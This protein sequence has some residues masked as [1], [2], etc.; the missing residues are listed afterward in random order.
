[1]KDELD[2]YVNCDGSIEHVYD[3]TL[4]GLLQEHGE[5]R[6]ER[7]SHVEPFGSGWMA[8]MSPVGGPMLL[9]WS[10]GGKGVPFATRAEALAAE[11][12]WLDLRMTMGSG[13]L[14]PRNGGR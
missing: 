8:D 3:D 5:A 7:A 12:A 2:I 14:L 1:M 9:D 6:T 13:S 4:S 11:L 10:R